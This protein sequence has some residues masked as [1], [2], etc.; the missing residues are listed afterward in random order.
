[1][2]Y[3]TVSDSEWMYP[4]I[5]D[6]ATAAASVSLVA[7]RGGYAS[8][9]IMLTDAP[10]EG[11]TVTADFSAP[12]L[13]FC[14]YRLKSV[15]V[16]GNPGFDGTPL[17]AGTVGFNSPDMN[18]DSGAES[19]DRR[20]YIPSQPCRRA[21]YRVYDCICPLG[22]AHRAVYSREA[23]F[24]PISPTH[25]G[26][27]ESGYSPFSPTHTG[28]AEDECLPCAYASVA[29]DDC[30]PAI[31]TGAADKGGVIALYVTLRFPDA[32]EFHGTIRAGNAQIPV[33]VA[34]LDAP[35]PHES[36][37]IAVG[38]YP[39]QVQ[40]YHGVKIG[41]PEFDRLEEMYLRLMRRSRQN[42]L[43]VDHP[44]CRRTDDGWKFDFCRMERDIRRG[45]EMGFAYFFIYGL[46]FRKS[47]SGETILIR[48]MDSESDEGIEYTRAYLTALREFLDD[49]GWTDRFAMGVADEPN[50]INVNR[51]VALA[52]RMKE[53]FPELALYDAVSYLPEL[54]GVLDICIPR[55]DEYENHRDRF[56]EM[57]EDGTRLWYYVCLFPRG[58]GYIN[59]FM[60]MPLLASRYLMWGC[61]GRGLGG[62]LHWSVNCF[63]DG[64][65][66]FE[67]NC[68][69]HVNAGSGSILP[70][71]D[72]H[73]VYPGEGEPWM[74]MRLEAQRQGGEE[75]EMLRIIAESDPT[76]AAAL[77]ER[78]FHTFSS[79]EYD[80]AVFDET[81]RAIMRAYCDSRSR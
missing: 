7:L 5:T 68:P 14:L 12:R 20:E 75:Y 2:K 52:R 4:D 37:K 26:E 11:V 74:S 17:T 65:D 39:W 18:V 67:C 76:R 8:F 32:G 41:T 55:A 13:E 10:A 49:R 58:G 60:D 66:P 9:Q 80:P 46:G 33:S 70:P 72:S 40:S 61:F 73:S 21:P 64:Q 36:L 50:S 78:A 28:A 30:I 24:C 53:I 81:R 79:V 38:Y 57:E 48:G 43:Y 15:R 42:V 62:F 34:V 47:W 44:E 56:T 3:I 69:D 35:V 63:M 19:A 45:F 1:M 31:Y 71:G 29:G 6:Y 23:D 22:D 51:Y 25:T 16:E 59:R 54:R 27:A 77:C